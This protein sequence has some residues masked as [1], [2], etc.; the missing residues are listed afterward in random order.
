MDRYH[1][2]TVFVAVAEAE[3]FS[4]AARSLGLSPP[5]VTRAITALEERL[6]VKLLNRTTRSVRVTEAGHTYLDAVR[7]ILSEIDAADEMAAG[8][9][10]EPRGLLSVT[11]PV[12][13]GRFFVTPAILDYLQRYPGMEVSALFLDRVVNL[14]EEGLDVGI[15]IGELPDSSMKAIRVGQVR[16]VVC[17]AP[18]YLAHN[19][20]PR[21]PADLTRHRLVA[22][23]SVTPTRDWKF[24]QGAATTSVRVKPSL[25]VSSIGAAIEAVSRGFGITRLMSYQVVP[26]LESGQLN[27]LLSNFEPPPMPIHVLHLEGRYASAKVRTF[28]DLMVDSLRANHALN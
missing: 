21:I 7:R 27:I 16:R 24:R 28:V 14:Q 25:S 26:Y 18:D 10:A 22:A 8:V 20:E 15:R 9:H 3:S 1:L 11:A 6:N 4:G 12:Q 13:F 23:T 5:A 17:A 2:M 19:P